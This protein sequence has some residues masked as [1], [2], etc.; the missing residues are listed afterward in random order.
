MRTRIILFLILIVQVFSLYAQEFVWANSVTGD[1]HEYGIEAIKDPLGNTYIIGYSTGNP[2]EFEGVT[3]PTNGRSDAFF[4]KLDTNKE[5]VWMKTVG[6]NDPNYP[7]EAIDIHIDPFGDIYLTFKSSGDNFKYDGQILSGIDSPGQYSGEGVLIKVNSNGEYIWHDSGTTSSSFQAI[8]T[9][10][11]G[12][13]YL[14]GNFS[15]SITLG[16]TIT[17]TNTSSG[18]TVDMLVAKYQPDGT[19]LWAKN[20]GGL[21][22]NTFAYGYDLEINSQSNEVIVLGHSDG[23]VFYDGVPTPINNSA[24]EGI[25]LISYE[26]DGTQNWVKAILEQ[27]SNFSCYGISLDIS[28]SG[29]IGA[30]GY[31]NSGLGLVGFYTSDGTVISEH[32][33]TSSESVRIYSIAFNESNEAYLSGWCDTDA[34][35]GINPGT[36]SLSST[37]GFIVKIDTSQQVKW[38]SEFTATGIGNQIYYSDHSIMYA[39]RIDD[40]FITNSGQIV[41]IHNS[42]DALFGEIIDQDLLSIDTHLKEDIAVYPNPTSGLLVVESN[43]LQKVEIYNISG[44]LLKTVRRKEID[45][46]QYSKGMYL[47]KLVTINGTTIKKIVLI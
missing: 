24:D 14:T 23:A 27:P 8:T 30:C 36:V 18:T 6:G 41:I 43:T 39:G 5:L 34:I 45:L 31:K 16:G 21:P 25:V 35:L 3:Y 10:S 47:L 15:S 11:N 26:L 4:A 28:N 38:V 40:D 29:V 12:N 42:G 44:V 22:H 17:L 33:Y 19:I 20:A 46:S 37:T 7:D 2:F 13:L 9:D 1:E 32:A